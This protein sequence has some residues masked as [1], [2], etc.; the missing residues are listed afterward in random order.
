MPRLNSATAI[1]PF[2]NRTKAHGLASNHLRCFGLVV[3]GFPTELDEHIV[4]G[5]QG[6]DTD[7]LERIRAFR[8]VD[9][10][11]V[12]S[13]VTERGAS[14]VAFELK[15]ITAKRFCTFKIPIVIKFDRCKR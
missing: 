3:Q 7:K 4:G 13:R 6:G 11:E 8:P 1:A 15:Q 14:T 9:R 10:P 12:A 2:G 5:I